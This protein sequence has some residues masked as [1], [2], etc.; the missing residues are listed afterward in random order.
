MTFSPP[1]RQVI[2][3]FAAQLGMTTKPAP[4]GSHSFRFEISGLLTF[5]AGSRNRVVISLARKPAIMSDAVKTSAL[6]MAGLDPGG[7]H[8]LHVGL[9]ANDQLVFAVMMNAEDFTLPAIESALQRLL[10][11]SAAIA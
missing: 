1:V 9:A 5:T 10:P 8:F 2:E 3:G 4:D 6:M 11:A 7:H